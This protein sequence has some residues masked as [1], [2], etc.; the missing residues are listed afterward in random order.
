MVNNGLPKEVSHYIFLSLI[1]IDTDSKVKTMV[2]N[3]KQIS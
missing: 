3:G 2:K 1:L